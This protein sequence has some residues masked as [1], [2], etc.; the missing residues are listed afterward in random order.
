MNFDNKFES[1]DIDLTNQKL[2]DLWNS[3]GQPFTDVY[4]SG[5][6]SEFRERLQMTE[7]RVVTV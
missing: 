1:L 2:T 4:G 6:I 7:G 3:E 5:K